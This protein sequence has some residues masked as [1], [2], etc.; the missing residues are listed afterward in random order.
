M[1]YALDFT[2]ANPANK[3]TDSFQVGGE[4]WGF[5]YLFFSA[6]PAFGIGMTVSYLPDNE[7]LSRTLTP[8]YE[9]DYAFQLPGVGN[10]DDTRAFGAIELKNLQLKGTIMIQYQA[11]GGNWSFNVAQIERYLESNSFNPNRQQAVLCPAYPL[12]IPSLSTTKTYQ[13]FNQYT[14]TTAQADLP[15]IALAIEFI[16]LQAPTST[17]GAGS[18]RKASITN[19]AAG[20]TGTTEVGAVQIQLINTGTTSITFGGATIPAGQRI[21]LSARGD[22]VIDTIPWVIPAG[23][24]ALLSQLA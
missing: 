19:L 23:G 1:S 2:G 12:I 5:P 14:I 17:T 22:D 4:Y 18:L 11:L 21:E 10:T 16:A 24:A 9:W 3:V 13:L 6:G 20:T 7:D 15:T 8:G